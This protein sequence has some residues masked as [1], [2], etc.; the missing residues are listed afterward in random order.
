MSAVEFRPT[1]DQ[2]AYTFGGAAAVMRIKPGTVLTL[3]TRTA[4]ARG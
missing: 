1:D 3:W 4:S 2:F